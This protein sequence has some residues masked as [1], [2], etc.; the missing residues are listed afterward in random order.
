VDAAGIHLQADARCA[1]PAAIEKTYRGMSPAASSSSRPRHS[2][3]VGGGVR[4]AAEGL[5][6]AGCAPSASAAIPPAGYPRTLRTVPRQ[7]SA[8]TICT[9]SRELSHVDG[10]PLSLSVEVDESATDDQLHDDQLSSP[11]AL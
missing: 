1:N 8:P 7:L 9:F 2:V 10:P 3:Q 6:Q 5:T 4:R 11:A